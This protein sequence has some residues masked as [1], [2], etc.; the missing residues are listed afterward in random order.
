MLIAQKTKSILQLM[1]PKQWIKNIFVMAPALFSLKFMEAPALFLALEATLL[2][3][4]ISASVYILNDWVDAKKDKLHPKKK[5]RPLASGRV[6][7]REAAFLLVTLMAGGI[8]FAW[9]LSPY[10]CA[11]LIGYLLN[12][13]AYTYYLKNRVI[14][15]VMSIAA[16]F[17]LRVIAGALVIDVHISPWL[18]MCTF[19]LALFLGFSKRRYELVLLQGEAAAHRMI[20]SEYSREFIDNMLSV[21]TSSVVISYFLYTFYTERLLMVTLPFVLY[22]IFRYQYL[23]YQKGEGGSPEDTLLSD[24]PLMVNVILWGLV[25]IGIIYLKR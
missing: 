11:V 14:L 21:V 13:I 12:N 6:Q 2:F 1:R 16:G 4:C 7:K 23:L 25:S 24:K 8:F 19:L 17:I 22:G 18:L 10:L 15:D 3:C 20:L 9:S 5:D